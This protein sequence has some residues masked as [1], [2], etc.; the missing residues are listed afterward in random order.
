MP[1]YRFYFSMT[2]A[3]AIALIFSH[4]L[5]NR[6]LVDTNCSHILVIEPFYLPY[7][8]NFEPIPREF[9]N[10]FFD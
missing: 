8:K 6:L 1:N 10:F 9:L 3:N 4:W 2:T 7:F 5:E